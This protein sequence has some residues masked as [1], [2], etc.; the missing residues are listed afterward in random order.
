MLRSG[1]VYSDVLTTKPSGRLSFGYFSLAEQ[2]KVPRRAGA[3]AR[4]K[5]KR[6]CK[7][8]LQSKHK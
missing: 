1:I 5:I 2:R 6:A 8:L 3:R 4:I 7:A